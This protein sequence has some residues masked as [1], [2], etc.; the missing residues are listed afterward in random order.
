MARVI[1]DT[2]GAKEPIEINAADEKGINETRSLVEKL[3]ITPIYS[4][5]L[6]LILDEAAELTPAA[7]NLLL[8]ELEDTPEHACIMFLTTD[9]TKLIETIKDRCD[10]V[11]HT[12]G[13]D[14]DKDVK[15]YSKYIA[16]MIQMRIKEYENGSS[17]WIPDALK[18]MLTHIDDHNIT[19]LIS[20]A[21]GSL[22]G[23]INGLY[24]LSIT[25]LLPEK[26]QVDKITDEI[27]ELLVNKQTVKLKFYIIRMD[28]SALH[29]TIRKVAHKLMDIALNDNDYPENYEL[30]AGLLSPMIYG[31]EK[32]TFTSRLLYTHKVWK[33][34]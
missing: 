32:E 5:Y 21:E 25:G 15:M 18:N 19:E 20:R 23:T 27:F 7:Q 13:L 2:I 3:H 29:G 1:A 30:I 14:E 10:M 11:I 33:R 12:H 9:Q 17:P 8:K 4:D 6:C 31:M 24:S 22:R 34:S 26:P 16:K 28:K